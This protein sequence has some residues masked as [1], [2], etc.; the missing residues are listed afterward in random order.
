MS[1]IFLPNNEQEVSDF[2]F[3]NYNAG[4]PIELTG[5]NSK[6]IGRLIQC[7]KS[8]SFKNMS[9]ILDYLP[10]ELYIKVLPGTK[11]DEV[12][13]TLAKKNQYLGF[14]PNDLGFLYEGR[15][16]SGT[17]G[18]VVSCNLSGPSRFKVGALRDH[19]LGFKGVNGSGAKIKSGGTVVKNVTGY[20]LSKV[21]S[22]SY[23]TLCGLTEITLKV[24]PLP[25]YEETFIINGVSY[26]EAINIF[27][28][29][30]DTSLEVS[31]ACYFPENN[32]SFLTL[33]DLKKNVSAIGLRVQGPK[34]SVV[35]RV[36]NLNNLF[37]NHET[38]VLD[39]YQTKIFWREI[40]NL[41]GFSNSDDF[42][43]KISLPI[44]NMEGF[45]NHFQN[46]DFKYF[47]DWGG[48]VAW[49]SVGKVNDLI[50]M[51]IYCLK[52]DGHL[53]VYRADESSRSSEDFL[54]N[55]DTNLKILSQK[56]KESF[57]PKGILNP[58]KMY[59]GI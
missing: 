8:L 22:G 59:P 19:V 3:E 16:N 51:R 44:T 18:G 47:L 6:K 27:Q 43:C 39:F 10:E 41:E 4:N 31:G 5:S 52:H 29:A 30:L 57:D 32:V 26:K 33:N 15:S 50:Q 48:N 55:S 11:L 37:S 36:E 34:K 17:I 21:I 53:T 58:G 56:L 2:I 24:S 45:L 40:K 12:E 23:G 28:K 9:G 7:S 38:A 13:S 49:C 1:D 54:T 14:E 42:I 46:S 20:D 25:E 35:E